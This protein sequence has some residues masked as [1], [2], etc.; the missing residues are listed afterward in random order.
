VSPGCDNCYAAALAWRLQ[1]M[2]NPRYQVDGD[3]R[4]S[5]LGFGLTLHWNLVDQ[6]RSCRQPAV[7]FVNSMAD[8]FH[9]RVPQEFIQRVFQTM[10]ETPRHTYQV[11]TKRSARLL[12]LASD[13][14]WPLNV[15]MGVS[16]EDQQHLTRARR[17]IN[18]PAAVRFLSVEPMLGP[19]DLEDGV[20][21]LYGGGDPLA[22]I[23]WV[24]AGGES[25][26]SARPCDPSWLRQLRDQCRSSEIPFF[27][28]Q[29]GG[30]GDKRGG[31]KA[32]LDGR[33]WH[34]MPA[35]GGPDVEEAG[36]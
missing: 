19:V 27:L 1:A 8:L 35:L 3:P 24:I 11:L 12:R 17:L 16:V 34:Q 25:G 26:P 23:H 20:L 6:P 4:T 7:V 21:P 30:R 28:K 10:A 2:G 33:L 13:L 22:P 36:S 32:L 9:D 14:P 29:L 18:V 31:E 5:G 15:W